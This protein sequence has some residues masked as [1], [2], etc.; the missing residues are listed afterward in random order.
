MTD[1]E[2]VQEIT[3]QASRI[4]D[5]HEARAWWRELTDVEKAELNNTGLH[6][7]LL[8]GAQIEVI[9]SSHKNIEL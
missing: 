8:N 6:H 1:Q 4:Q 7:K 5:L 2:K 9:W 3:S